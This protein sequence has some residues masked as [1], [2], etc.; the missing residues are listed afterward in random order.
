MQL[1]AVLQLQ[2]EHEESVRQKEQQT[3]HEYV[4]KQHHRHQQYQALTTAHPP[5]Q[6]K[7]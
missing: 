3:K 7:L 6:M 5:Q 2:K 1:P 4:Q